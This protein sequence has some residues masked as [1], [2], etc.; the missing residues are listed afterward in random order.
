MSVSFRKGDPK[1]L[2]RLEQREVLW[3]FQGPRRIVRAALYS[4]ETGT[5]L[6]VYLGTELLYSQ[7]ATFDL[8][9]LY[10]RANALEA[11]LLAQGWTAIPST[12]ELHSDRDP[13]DQPE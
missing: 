7:L 11:Q 10:E 2:P 9:P 4:V 6:R 3:R 8:G 1:P 12:S 13:D 5:E